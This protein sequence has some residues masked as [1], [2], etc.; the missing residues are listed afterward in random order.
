MGFG[1]GSPHCLMDYVLVGEIGSCAQKRAP[2][3]QQQV[4]PGVASR[5]CTAAPF[6]GARSRPWRVASL[7]TWPALAD[8]SAGRGPR[9]GGHASRGSRPEQ[10]T[11]SY[12]ECRR[13]APD[14]HRPDGGSWHDVSYIPVVVEDARGS[15]EGEAR[16]RTLADID[17]PLMSFTTDTATFSQ[18]LRT[19]PTS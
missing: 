10:S 1:F 13:H 12:G 3:A 7:T 15:L 6:L 17:Y 11:A 9:A 14:R 5:A 2:C 18:A 19:A 8:T 16:R 4:F